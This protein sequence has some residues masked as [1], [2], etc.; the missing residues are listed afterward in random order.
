MS[1]DKVLTVQDVIDFLQS[2][3]KANPDAATYQVGRYDY[4]DFSISCLGFT[5]GCTSIE[6]IDLP[7]DNGFQEGVD[8]ALTTSKILSIN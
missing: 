1:N 6:L 3:V 5:F 8:S 2:E 7:E 4:D